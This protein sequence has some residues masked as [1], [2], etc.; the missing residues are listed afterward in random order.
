MP[1]EIGITE[2]ATQAG[3]PAAYAPHLRKAPL[4]GVPQKSI[5]L[6]YAR[7]DQTVPN[8]TTSAIIRAGDLRT[9]TTLFRNDLAFAGNPSFPK[10]PHTFLTR[11]A[12]VAPEVAAVALRATGRPAAERLLPVVCC[13]ELGR[14]IGVIAVDRLLEA[15][16]RA[17][18][19]A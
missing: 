16:A 2:W 10:N 9:Q 15:L 19:P 8:P 6:Q 5:I 12:G 1:A 14:P 7:G 13:D 3:N 17:A 4:A 11:I 18:V